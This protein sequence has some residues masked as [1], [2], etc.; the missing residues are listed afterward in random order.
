MCNAHKYVC[1]G[2]GLLGLAYAAFPDNKSVVCIISILMFV[3]AFECGPGPLFFVM[4]CTLHA[5]YTCSLLI[6][7]AQLLLCCIS[8]CAV[9]ILRICV[10]CVCVV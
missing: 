3:G 6:F 8:C 9:C 2:T 7:S 10:V 1:T 5:F 4:V